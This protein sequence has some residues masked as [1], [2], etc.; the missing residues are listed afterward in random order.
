MKLL[1]SHNPYMK[2]TKLFLDEKEYTEQGKLKSILSGNQSFQDLIPELI[3]SMKE[4]LNETSFD[5]TFH[6]RDLDFEDLED[7][8]EHYKGKENYNISL[9]YKKG[10]NSDNIKEELEGLIKEMQMGPYEEL[11]NPEIMAKFKN[12]FESLEAEVGVIATMSSGKST[13]INAF[14]GR[15]VLPSKNE[16]CTATVCRIKD[17]DGKKD[18]RMRYYDSDGNLVQDWKN[19]SNTSPVD[20]IEEI[21]EKGN[22]VEKIELE[23]DVPYINSSNMQLVLVDT[24][25]PNNSQNPKHQEH[26][27]GFIKNSIHKPLVLYVINAT[28]IAIKDDETF[29]R[30]IAYAMKRAGKQS[31]D[32]FIFAINKID[33]IDY[34]KEDVTGVINAVKNYLETFGIENPKVFPLTAEYAKIIR[35]DSNSIKLTKKQ[36]KILNDYDYFL[37]EDDEDIHN[38]EM[39]MVDKASLSKRNKNQ[40]LEKVKGLLEAGKDKDAALIFSGVPAIEEYINDYLRKYAYV[41][42]ISDVVNSFINFIKNEKLMEGI[43]KELAYNEVKRKEI[44]ESIKKIEVN[45]EKGKNAKEFD[46]K[47]DEIQVDDAEIKS[48]DN[49]IDNTFNN[50]TDNFFGKTTPNSIKQLLESA[51]KDINLL[52]ANLK[53]SAMSFFYNEVTFKVDN[54]YSEYQTYIRGLLPPD[55]SNSFQGGINKSIFQEMVRKDT[56]NFLSE[57]TKESREKIINKKWYNPFTWFKKNTII[58]EEYVNLKDLFNEYLAPERK[59]ISAIIDEVKFE[60]EAELKSVK[61]DFRSKKRTI[62]LAIE[63]KLVE[64]KEKAED[65]EKMKIE[66][67]EKEKDRLWLENISKKLAK[68]LSV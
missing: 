52:V 21:N 64:I 3:S 16:A 10:A 23:C 40:L 67:K 68:I 26:T 34:E 55:S 9:N 59:R 49:M 20:D 61:N 11:K 53:T 50:L 13:L 37:P 2:E 66:S 28:Q 1:L 48:M 12:T 38:F 63:N 7:V 47:I 5:I 45:I 56:T 62:D 19:I 27:L 6:G 30:E 65:I 39:N 42:K 43:E 35:F 33:C 8:V 4:E 58:R 15:N 31:K 60:V 24:P 44:V 32:R 41:S 14:M 22:N 57:N 51:T 18:Y 25:G 17:I 29:L 46:K 36:K 54:I